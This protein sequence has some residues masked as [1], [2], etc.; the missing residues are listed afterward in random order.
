MDYKLISKTYNIKIL[1]D[2]NIDEIYE[3]C[4]ENKV[5]YKYCPP[6]VTKDTIKE[7]MNALPP[8]KTYI[9]KYYIGFYSCDSLIAVMD[10][11]LNYPNDKSV[12]VGFFMVDVKYQGRNIGS[13]IIKEF[14]E[15]MKSLGYVNVRLG[16][17]SGNKQ[18]ES[19]WLKNGFVST[20]KSNKEPNYTINILNKTL[21]F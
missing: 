5:F 1:E 18:S 7:D 13:N 2:T 15:Y 14:C 11:I 12:L 4:K 20:G 17:A 19:F 6:F 9:D 21:K 16:Y 3:L 8:N 10:L